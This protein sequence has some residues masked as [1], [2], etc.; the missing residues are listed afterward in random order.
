MPE[1]N[2]VM[3]IDDFGVMRIADTRISLDS[4]VA[5]FL[6]GHSS[7]TIQ[8]Q[9][10]GLSLE[11]VERAIEYY[12]SHQQQVDDYL[13]R[14]AQIWSQLRSAAEST[15][16]ALAERLRAIRLTATQT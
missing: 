3:V 10:P 8:Q 6:Q 2:S 15:P 11:Q 7:A 13:R 12:Q 4:I 5:A 9:Y 1:E 14:Q 16:S